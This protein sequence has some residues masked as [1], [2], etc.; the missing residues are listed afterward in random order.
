[1]LDAFGQRGYT[2]SNLGLNLALVRLPTIEALNLV[3]KIFTI[4]LS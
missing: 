2:T 4:D 3:T 1:M